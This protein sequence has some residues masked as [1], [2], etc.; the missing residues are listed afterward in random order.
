MFEFQKLKQ[1]NHVF[2]NMTHLNFFIGKDKRNWE[3]K[4]CQVSINLK[5]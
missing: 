5:K 4:L 2:K 3:T 1:H